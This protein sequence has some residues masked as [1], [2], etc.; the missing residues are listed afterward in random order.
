MNETNKNEQQCNRGLKS[1]LFS[2]T[3]LA[4]TGV[5]AIVGYVAW[6]TYGIKVGALLPYLPYL[7][8][9]ACPLMHVFMHKGHGTHGNQNHNPAAEEETAIVEEPKDIRDREIVPG[10]V[11]KGLKPGVSVPQIAGI[12]EKVRSR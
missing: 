5:L 1:F 3:G 10:P 7:V 12:R 6:T 9:L 2:K 11:N 4:L 8:L